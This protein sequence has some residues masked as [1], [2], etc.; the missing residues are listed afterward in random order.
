[1]FFDLILEKF[2]SNPHQ[3]SYG[4]LFAKNDFNKKSEVGASL[5]YEHISSF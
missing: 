1:M 2:V 4:P 3:R 5:S